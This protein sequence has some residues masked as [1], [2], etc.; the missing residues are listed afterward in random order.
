M[1]IVSGEIPIKPEARTEA[2]AAAREM[3]AATRKEDGCISY[4]FYTSVADENVVR[5]FEEWDSGD[6][7]DARFATPHMATLLQKLPEI[8]A[9]PANVKRY[10]ISSVS[11]LS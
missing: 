3:A 5:V 7:L 9:G 1:I 2:M 11:S 6:A 8:A 4:M 10:E